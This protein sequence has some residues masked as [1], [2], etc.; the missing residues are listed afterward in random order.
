MY[1]LSSSSSMPLAAP[2]ATTDV[3][4]A[5]RT[6]P[7]S[8][9]ILVLGPCA[10]EEVRGFSMDA[11]GPNCPDGRCGNRRHMNLA[12]ADNNVL[13]EE[14][15]VGSGAEQVKQSDG[16]MLGT[17]RRRGRTNEVG[18]SERLKIS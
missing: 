18:M 15:V 9:S 1:A 16:A 12:D 8:I 2:F 13:K 6:A 11:K 17:M 7:R 10:A 4:S 14:E 3:E 5:G